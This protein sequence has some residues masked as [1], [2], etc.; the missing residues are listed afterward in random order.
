VIGY[1]AAKLGTRP[2]QR[3]GRPVADAEEDHPD[4]GLPREG[5]CLCCLARLAGQLIGSGNL[6]RGNWQKR[7]KA[8]IG[9]ELAIGIYCNGDK[10]GKVGRRGRAVGNRGQVVSGSA[11]A[12][13]GQQG[14]VARDGHP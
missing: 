5:N 8:A 11:R 3:A 7:V 4:R 12:E 2:A 13:A 9:S 1:Q 6:R 10:V 14:Y